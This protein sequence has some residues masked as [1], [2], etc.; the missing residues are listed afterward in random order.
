MIKK[1]H[2]IKKL[3]YFKISADN[4]VSQLAMQKFNDKHKFIFF[5]LIRTKASFYYVFSSKLEE[6]KQNSGKRPSYVTKLW[7]RHATQPTEQ[8]YHTASQP[9]DQGTNLQNKN[10]IIWTILF[11]QI[12]RGKTKLDFLLVQINL[13]INIKTSPEPGDGWD[14]WEK[15]CKLWW[16]DWRDLRD[17]RDWWDCWEWRDWQD[18]RENCHGSYAKL[19]PGLLALFINLFLGWFLNLKI[20]LMRFLLRCFIVL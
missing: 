10:T 12:G 19:T 16:P 3:W 13:F 4:W 18:W 2:Q 7:R 17:W 8:Q 14:G 11:G 5:N 20:F 6:S 9:H 1:I 15:E